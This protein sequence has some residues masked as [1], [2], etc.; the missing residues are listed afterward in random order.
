[1]IEIAKDALCKAQE[2]QVKYANKH[3]RYLTFAI[4]DQVLLF[5]KNANS[6]VDRNHSTRKLIP[7]FMGSYTIT[8]VVSEIVYRLN[9]SS[10]MKIHPVF[11]VFLLKPYKSSSN[12]FLHPTSP[13]TIMLPETE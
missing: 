8:Q 2:R 7:R 11:Y 5:M 13:T 4:G 12:E 10:A 1:M 6:L 3:R 9:L